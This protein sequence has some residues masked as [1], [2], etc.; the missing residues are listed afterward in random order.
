MNMARQKG[1][2]RRIG[3][4]REPLS[5]ER[6]EHGRPLGEAEKHSFAGPGCLHDRSQHGARGLVEVAVCGQHCA[7]IGQRFYRS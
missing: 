6:G 5:I 1:N 7:E 3:Q 4:Q 2:D